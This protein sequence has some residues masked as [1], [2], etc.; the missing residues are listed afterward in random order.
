MTFE[1]NSRICLAFRTNN[2]LAAEKPRLGALLRISAWI[3]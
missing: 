1:E 2:L 3:R